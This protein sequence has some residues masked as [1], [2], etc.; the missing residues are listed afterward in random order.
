MPDCLGATLTWRQLL[1]EA[2]KRVGRSDARRIVAEA[3]GHE[4]AEVV[5]GLAQPA[6]ERAVSRFDAMV[7]RR[8]AG[9][10]LQYVLGRWGFRSL[11]L[12]VDH[13]A[14]IP[15]PETEG[16]AGRAIDELRHLA[17]GRP[18]TVVDLGTGSGA[19][20]LSLAS[21]V[22]TATVWATDRS[23]HALAVARA[24][25]AGLG[26]PGTRVRLA[27]G[28]WFDA[29]PPELWG[30]V[31]LVVA[32]PPYVAQD[33]MLPDEVA[34]WEP[35]EALIAG[36]TGLEAIT[37]ILAEAPAWLA[38]PGSLVLELA[39]HQAATA[40][41]V[42]RDAGFSDVAVHP[43]LAGRDRTLV[44]RLTVLDAEGRSTTSSV[45]NAR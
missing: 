4:G 22:L 15:R 28:D 40:S 27:E 21:E 17:G 44:A 16:V 9:E 30:A 8:E 2:A 3:A 39:P 7:G 32:N 14:L 45:Q 1:D 29:L 38:R 11:D 35:V 36:P 23:A 42:A 12:M 25:L 34:A 19:I 24:N 26:R 31:D 41:A 20:A 37:A 5:I 10:P 18:S 33:E 13:R 43:D 6:T